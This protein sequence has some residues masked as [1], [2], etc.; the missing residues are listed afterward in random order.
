MDDPIKA[1]LEKFEVP[2]EHEEFLFIF[3]L[4]YVAKA[5]GTIGLK[6]SYKVMMSAMTSV[7][8]PKGKEDKKALQ[9]FLKEQ[10]TVFKAKKNLP[11]SRILTDAIS[12]LMSKQST[13]EAQAIRK[14]MYDACVKVAQTSG[15]MF[16]E[17]VSDEERKML[18]SF[19]GTIL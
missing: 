18:E 4:L 10:I 17:K 9:D 3:P 19:F 14:T 15:P 12:A 16:K 11:D 6:E 5:D 1:A 8:P 13:D 2:T 7:T